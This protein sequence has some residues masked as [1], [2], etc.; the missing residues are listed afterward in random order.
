MSHKCC[1]EKCNNISTWGYMPSDYNYCDDCVPRG[2]SC[3][4]D[5]S[6]N[7]ILGNDGKLLP[8]CEYTEIDNDF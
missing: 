2:C 7:Q 3:N 5:E 6:G 8:C 4:E 1:V